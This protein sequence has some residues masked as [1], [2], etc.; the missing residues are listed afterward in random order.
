MQKTLKALITALSHEP[1]KTHNP[2]I[3]FK[4]MSSIGMLEEKKNLQE[5]ILSILPYAITLEYQETIQGNV[6]Q[7]VNKIIKH[8]KYMIKKKQKPS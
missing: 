6:W 2:S 5:E 4:M 3:Q 1:M 7:K 8:L